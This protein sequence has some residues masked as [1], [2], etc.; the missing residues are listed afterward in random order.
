MS[1]KQTLYKVIE[2]IK[3]TTINRLNKSKKWK[4]GYNKEHDIVVI[5]KTGQ[6]GDI[7]EIQNLKIA[8]PKQPKDVYSNKDKKWQKFD[9]PKELSKLKNI[10]DWRDYPEESKEKWY[11]YIDAEFE[12]R[13]AGF[14]FNNNGT[15]TYIT[16]T[17]YM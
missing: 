9:Y 12:R 1:Y 11:D 8:L 4:Y 2:P 7:Y 6:I 13:E 10:F 16:G 3:L 5:S 15:P 14:W 17:H